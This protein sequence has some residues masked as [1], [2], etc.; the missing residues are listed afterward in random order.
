MRRKLRCVILK[1][2]KRAKTI[3]KF[4]MKLGVP[5]RQSWALAASGKGCWRKAGSP[6]AQ[7]AMN[8]TWFAKQK[9]IDSIQ[10]YG[11]FKNDRNRRGTEQICPVV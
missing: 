10:W 2:L 4:L 1:R 3:G 7:H 5:A 9:W 6:P 11:T 8:N